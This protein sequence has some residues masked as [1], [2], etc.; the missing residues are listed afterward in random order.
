MYNQ[1]TDLSLKVRLVKVRY[2]DTA[3]GKEV[4]GS[5]SFFIEHEDQLA[6]RNNV[7]ERDSILTPFD[8][9]RENFMKMSVF[10]YLIGN[11]DWFISSRR[12]VVI[13]RSRRYKGAPMQFPMILI[14]RV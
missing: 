10:E 3:T 5:H 8:L 14:L 13:F 12:N 11:K 9:D 6:E 1:V 7:F 2:F 4:L